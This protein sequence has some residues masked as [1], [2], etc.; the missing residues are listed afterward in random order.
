MASPTESWTV[1]RLLTWTTDYLKRHGSDQPRLEAE[2]L[3]AH[4]R[5]TPR[6]QLYTSFHEEVDDLQRAA[7]REVVRERAAGKPVAY[8][9]GH[10]EFYSLEFRVT[11]DVLIPRP[12]TE[13]LVLVMLDVAQSRP[14]GSPPPRIADVGTGSGILAVCAAR[15]LPGAQVLAIDCSRAALDVAREN[16]QRHAADANVELVE[17]DLFT[18]VPEERK[19]DI[20]VSN[21]PYVSQSEYEQLPRDVRDYEPQTALLAGTTGAEIVERLIGQAAERLAPRGWLAMEI[22]PMI[23]ELTRQHFANQP[24][25]DAPQFRKDL[26]GHVRVV[27]AQRRD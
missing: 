1:G 3:L 21:P 5:Q 27:Y 6:I 24:A 18:A 11:P 19:F 20:I 15:H 13:L 7:F 10:R 9:V 12:E 17:S 26:A 8:L 4:V 14:A 25:F 23:A 22:S 2:V 16:V